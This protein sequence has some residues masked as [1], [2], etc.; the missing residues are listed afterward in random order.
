MCGCVRDTS[1][2]IFN[3]VST[4]RDNYMSATAYLTAILENYWVA[5]GFL[6][7]LDH[8]TTTSVYTIGGWR[9]LSWLTEASY[10]NTSVLYN[11]LRHR[12]IWTTLVLLLKNRLRTC[13]YITIFIL[14]Y[15]LDAFSNV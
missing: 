2:V 1:I 10:N 7:Q 14:Y 15:S 9:V 3:E 8:I 5:V 11:Y 6:G 12:I 13:K 4:S